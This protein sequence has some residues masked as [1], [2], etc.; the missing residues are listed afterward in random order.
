MG[1]PQSDGRWKAE[2]GFNNDGLDGP[3]HRIIEPRADSMKR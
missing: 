1:S 2:N 3:D